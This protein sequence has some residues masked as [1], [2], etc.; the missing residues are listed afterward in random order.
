MSKFKIFDG[1]FKSYEEA[2]N[3]S[4]GNIFSDVKYLNKTLNELKKSK[5]NSTDLIKFTQR[6]RGFGNFLCSAYNFK[7]KLNILDFGGGMG[8][9]YLHLKQ[10][11][12]SKN[13]KKINY[14]IVDN[15]K[16]ILKT[17]NYNKKISFYETLPKI[18]VDVFVSSS[19][20]QY[21][22]NLKRF[23]KTICE[24]KPK[25]IVLLDV[26]AGNIPNYFSLQ[27]YYNIKTPHAFLN[28]NIFLKNF[29][30]MGYDLIF[31]DITNVD[32]AGLNTQLNMSNFPKKYRLQNSKNFIL[33]RHK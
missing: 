19:S 5:R 13:F 8:N 23:I 18:R 7:K 29:K 22:D 30:N 11:I 21:L 20:I 16:V 9:G 32:R 4:S 24:Y 28:E 17:K 14:S 2:N 1:I 6:Y 15:S 3:F 27:K 31:S 10:T 33:K 25:Y 12:P 26:F